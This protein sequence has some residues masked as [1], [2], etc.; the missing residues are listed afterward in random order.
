MN[1]YNTFNRKLFIVI[2][3]IFLI[4]VSLLCLLPFI[5]LIS[6]SLSG[7]SAV[8]AG[9][10]KFWPVDFNLKSYEHVIKSQAFIKSV[11]VSI[12]RELLGVSVNM[13]LTVLAAYPLSKE[14]N[15]FKSRGI[16]AWFFIVT[17]LFN[18]GLIP[19]YMVIKFTGLMDTIWALVIPG[20]IPVFNMIILL[21]F[22]RRL[23]KE[24][25]EAAFIDGAGHWRTLCEIF[26]PISKPALATVALFCIVFHWN[27]WFDG[28]ILMNTSEHYPLQSY[29]QTVIID[30][31]AMIRRN[32][33]Y[34]TLLQFINART[35][36]AAQL[37][38]ATI[39][40][41]I[42]YPFLQKYFTTGLVLGS[43]KG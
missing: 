28:L 17:L 20:G 10:V 31:E 30:P 19:W 36:K 21:N 42:A 15:A 5:N 12:K 27:S 29:L 4:F 22:F 24:L 3:Y 33:D 41:L 13:I 1:Y 25:E 7:S 35:S 34:K 8:M 39:P 43:V 11:Y 2:N 23:P 38:I 9:D 16:Y 32:S 40:V 26:I 18:S 14:K 6:I 37:F